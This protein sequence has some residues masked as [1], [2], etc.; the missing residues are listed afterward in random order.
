MHY[1]NRMPLYKRKIFPTRKV[2]HTE[3]KEGVVIFVEGPKLNPYKGV[4]CDSLKIK[5]RIESGTFED[6]EGM[7]HQAEKVSG[8]DLMTEQIEREE[9]AYEERK[10]QYENEK[11]RKEFN[12]RL[13]KAVEKYH[14]EVSDLVD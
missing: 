5:S 9:R 6:H 4:P 14:P 7:P 8:A 1:N 12:S 11:K 3:I 2:Y 10:T 13:K